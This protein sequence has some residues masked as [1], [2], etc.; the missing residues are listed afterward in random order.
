MEKTISPLDNRYFSKVQEIS[1]Y[2]S[3]KSWVYYRLFVEVE[4]LKKLVCV[5]NMN[6]ISEFVLDGDQ[7][8]S[9]L[10]ILNNLLEDYHKSNEG[11]DK[12][13]EIEKETKH[14]I[15]AIEYYI[16]Y[17]IRNSEL[18]NQE[19]DKIINLIHYGLTSQDINSVAFSL[20]LKCCMKN[21]IIPCVNKL[22]LQLFFMGL[23]WDKITICAYTHGQPAVPTK[24]GKEIKVYSNRLSYW[25]KKIKHH[26]YYTKM[27]GAVGNLSAHRFTFDTINWPEFFCEFLEKQGLKRWSYTTQITNYDD[28]VH[29]FSLVVGMNYMLVDLCQD[30]WLYIS[31]K[32]FKLSKSKG[33]VGSSTM[34]QKVN[35]IDFENAEGNLKLANAG[36]SFMIEKLQ[37]SRL[38]RDLTDSTVLRNVGTY[39]GHCVLAYKNIQTGFEKLEV[40]NKEIENDLNRHPECL[41]E[42][43]Q[44]LLRRYNINNGY[45]IVRQATQNKIYTNLDDFKASILESLRNNE[46]INNRQTVS[47]NINNDI[48][49]KINELNFDTY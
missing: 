3:L 21:A 34:P 8:I 10:T 11:Y 48:I 29:L 32:Y 18:Y 15:K 45:D 19:L 4:Y 36:L 35:P 40:N 2:F 27:G 37:V 39:L 30:M 25:M 44:M 31:R 14:D 7:K 28:I 17:Y 9:L 26:Q 20:Q 42:A 41:S 47:I 13:M 12:I 16:G 33:Q 38:Q 5:L 43:I 23:R 22:V 1:K 46:I 6:E 49:E 24:L